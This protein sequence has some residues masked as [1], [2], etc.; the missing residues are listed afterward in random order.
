MEYDKF[1]IYDFSGKDHG[2][3]KRKNIKYPDVAYNFE[4]KKESIER[5]FSPFMFL[6]SAAKSNNFVMF[7]GFEN[8]IGFEENDNIE[9]NLK[10]IKQNIGKNIFIIITSYSSLF[11]L[12]KKETKDLM[13][14]LQPYFLITGIDDYGYL[15]EFRK[16]IRTKNIALYNKSAK[17]L[18]ALEAEWI[19]NNCTSVLLLNNNVTAYRN[20]LSQVKLL[21]IDIDKVLIEYVKIV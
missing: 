18:S 20:K 5:M 9:K 3:L 8:I 10:E 19:N 14:I 6:E 15:K 13:N 7:L 4:M 2:L 16:Y 21:S 1:I 11:F 17:D 12:K